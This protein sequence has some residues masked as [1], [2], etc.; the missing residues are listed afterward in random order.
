MKPVIYS[1]IAAPVR[2]FAAPLALAISC[3]FFQPVV[4]PVLAESPPEFDIIGNTIQFG[5]QDWYQVQDASDFSTL[6]EGNDDCT[7]PNG[8]YNIINLSRLE[9]FEG[10]EVGSLAPV[11]TGS[12]V[13]TFAGEGWYQV[14]NATTFESVCEGGTQ[15]TVPAG[16]YI[17]INHTTG[18]RTM[19]TVAGSGGTGGGSGGGNIDYGDFILAGNVVTFL[20][21]DW[22]QVQ[23]STD[24]QTAC[25]GN[26]PCTVP[27]GSYTV[28]NHSTGERWDN[29]VINASEADAVINSGNYRAVVRQALEVFSGQAYDDR[30]ALF[31]YFQSSR[32]TGNSRGDLNL[33]CDNG[34]SQFQSLLVTPA[35]LDFVESQYSGCLWTLP[36]LGNGDLVN[37]GFEDVASPGGHRR[38][39]TN[40]TSRID[41]ESRM[42]VNGS[43]HTNCC[44]QGVTFES[45]D[46]DYFFTYPLGTL[47]VADATTKHIRSFSDGLLEG[48]FTMQSSAFGD[49]DIQA[50][51]DV[52]FR[53]DLDTTA[54][55]GTARH[56]WEFTSGQ[57]RLIAPSDGS[58]VVVNAD[59][60]DFNTLTVT[61]SS[62]E[63]SV[64][65]T[66]NWGDWHDALACTRDVCET[67][68]VPG[69]EFVTVTYW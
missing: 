28:I 6:C 38:S 29:L 41:S 15:C 23:S 37:G 16:T 34:G 18:E 4:Q 45:I 9:R 50:I 62:A 10:I 61:I 17:V 69:V 65:L 7:V 24:Y 43:H 63:E 2:R 64:T 30:L 58:S 36:G 1:A 19:E 39:F 54:D 55:Q 46:L 26:L 48:N 59:T 20:T 22:F 3:I 35:S 44:G 67:F 11:E 42:E 14:Q 51:T 57:L 31:P 8:T 40:F 32:V 68:T 56:L 52:P 5:F 21:G 25:E 49:A 47:R 12:G 33:V 53:W 27:G 60:G 13:I 66:E